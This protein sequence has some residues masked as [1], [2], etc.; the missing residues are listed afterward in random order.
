MT[1]TVKRKGTYLLFLTFRNKISVNIG[2]LGTADI[3]PGEYC[4]TGSAMN[5]LDGRLKRHFAKEKNI[6]WHIDRLTVTADS[7]EAY[8]SLTVPEC[9]LSEMAAESGCRPVHKGFGCSDCKC[10]T[11]L[12]SVDGNSKEKLLNM[13]GAT[14][15][16]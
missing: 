8:V 6:R 10:G 13:S 12:F 14:L 3:G 7:M 15:F 16:F 9:T 5:G 11:H 2:S 1:E 4:Y